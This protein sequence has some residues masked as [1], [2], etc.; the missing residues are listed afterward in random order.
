MTTTPTGLI[1]RADLAQLNQLSDRAGLLRF[2]A[3][4]SVFHFSTCLTEENA[5]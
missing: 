2:C 3:L 5:S 4:Y 1:P